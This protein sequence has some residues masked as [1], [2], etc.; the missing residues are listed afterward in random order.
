MK[1]LQ[2]DASQA[3]KIKNELVRIY[4]D[5][6][7]WGIENGVSSP[8]SVGKR[9]RKSLNPNGLAGLTAIRTRE[10]AMETVAGLLVDE[11]GWLV[12]LAKK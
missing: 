9:T 5:L 3:G 12:P 1:S 7:R 10:R 4:R 8:E 11:L 6:E 2:K